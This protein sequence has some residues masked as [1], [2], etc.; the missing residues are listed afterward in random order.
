MTAEPEP[1]ETPE[2]APSGASWAAGGCVLTV[3]GLAPLAVIFAASREAGVLVTVGAT[4]GMVW[5]HARR[6]PPAPNPA[7]PPPPEGAD[8]AKPQFTVMEDPNNPA[9]SLVLWATPKEQS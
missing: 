8:D 7:P 1:V 4:T 2:E 9:R 6:V 3:L 5:W